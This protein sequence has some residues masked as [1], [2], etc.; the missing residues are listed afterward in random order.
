MRGRRMVE[1][2]SGRPRANFG[3]ESGEWRARG[4]AGREAPEPP[5]G[6]SGSGEGEPWGNGAGQSP[7]AISSLVASLANRPLIPARKDSWTWAAGMVLPFNTSA[8]VAQASC[9][10]VQ[11]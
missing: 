7:A 5:C 6:G 8:R 3:Q 11:A 1:S 10:S 2:T 4:G 9:A